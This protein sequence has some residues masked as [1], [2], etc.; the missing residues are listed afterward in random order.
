MIEALQNK[1]FRQDRTNTRRLNLEPPGSPPT[2]AQLIPV[3]KKYLVGFLFQ[4][5]CAG[6]I[7]PLLLARSAL[8]WF[9]RDK[10]NVP[11]RNTKNFVNTLLPPIRA[12]FVPAAILRG[13]PMK[14]R[15]LPPYTERSKTR[16][17]VAIIIAPTGRNR[18]CIAARTGGL[19]QSAGTAI[20]QLPH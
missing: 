12:A 2:G 1:C 9:R 19:Y 6:G 4:I 8:M 3:I 15:T 11:I 20:A 5:T 10:V 16:C 18:I 7:P 14:D 17:S 13:S